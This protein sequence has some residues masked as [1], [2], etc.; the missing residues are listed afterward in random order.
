MR[1]FLS[2]AIALVIVIGGLSLFAVRRAAAD[3]SQQD[4]ASQIIARERAAV[5]A[6]Q[7]KNKAFWTDYLTDDATSFAAQSPYLETDPKTNF[8]PKFDQYAE[9]F[10]IMDWE[11]YNPR[12]QVYGD[13]AV[14]TYNEGATVNFGGRVLNYTGKVTTVYVKQGNTWRAVH[15]H[16]SMNP[17]AQ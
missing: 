9:Q 7:N 3:P 15:Q 5:A 10:K 12:V 11:M 8:I 17:G 16:E 6:W 2:I 4:I 13:T 1:K 14:L